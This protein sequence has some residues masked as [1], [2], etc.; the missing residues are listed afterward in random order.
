ML[1]WI[2]HKSIDTTK[3][4]KELK[5]KGIISEYGELNPTELE[6]EYGEEKATE[7]TDNITRKEIYQTYTV[8][9]LYKIAGVIVE[10]IKIDL[11]KKRIF[12]IDVEDLE[13]VVNEI[14]R[15]QARLE[16]WTI[17]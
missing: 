14:Y 15:K 16:G 9:E 13:A 8:D 17:C 10:D 11:M 7:I 2:E 1:R 6:K 3:I 5:E 12:T 4:I